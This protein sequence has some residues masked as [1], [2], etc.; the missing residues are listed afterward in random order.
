MSF[1]LRMGHV[2]AKERYIAKRYIEDEYKEEEN[3]TSLWL[4]KTH[5][6]NV[7]GVFFCDVR[8]DIKKRRQIY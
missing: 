1:G 8:R 6:G 2:G 5:N 3:E 4:E 7:R